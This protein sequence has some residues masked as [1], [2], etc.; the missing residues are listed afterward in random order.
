MSVVLLQLCSS[1]RLCYASMWWSHVGAVL[2]YLADQCC[3]S[4]TQVYFGLL[5]AAVLRYQA[6]PF[7]CGWW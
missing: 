3:G 5:G 4:T 1:M 6:E 7:S 2:L